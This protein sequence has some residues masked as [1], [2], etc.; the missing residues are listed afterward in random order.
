MNQSVNKCTGP[1]AVAR[2]DNETS[3]LIDHNEIH[4]L[5]ENVERD[6]FAF[7]R[8]V[9][10]FGNFNRNRQT[11]TQLVLGLSNGRTVNTDLALGDQ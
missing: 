7:R 9:L 1:V 6:I 4:I 5:I 8:R 11:I 2:V 3:G 10:W